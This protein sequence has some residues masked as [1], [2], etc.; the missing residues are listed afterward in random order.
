[1]CFIE[2]WGGHLNLKRGGRRQRQMCI[3][4]RNIDNGTHRVLILKRHTGKFSIDQPA[5]R[6]AVPALTRQKIG[7]LDSVPKKVI[8][9]TGRAPWYALEPTP[10][11]KMI[12]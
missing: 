10:K 8:F 2:R 3:S 9:L 12:F 1:M 5:G 6:P 11:I 4:E 7:D